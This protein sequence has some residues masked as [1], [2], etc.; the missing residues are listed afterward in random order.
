MVDHMPKIISSDEN[1]IPFK[2][3][4]IKGVSLFVREDILSTMT[5]HADEG[6][7]DNKEVMGLLIGNVN[8]D[9]EGQYATVT[10]IATTDLDADVVSVRFREDALEDLFRN[11]DRCK[12]DAIVGWY[13]SHL[14]V[15]CYLSDTD[16]RTHKGIFGDEMGF[17]IVI[18]PSVS[19]LVPFSF[20]E[21][22]Q[23]KVPMVVM[24]ND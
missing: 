5:D 10:D 22:D 17:A 24:T 1:S 11:I 19:T 2:K 21:G 13:H 6:Y 4:P 18:D 7:L 23:R 9:D 8:A 3:R 16:I 20:S 12:G 15:G 14:G